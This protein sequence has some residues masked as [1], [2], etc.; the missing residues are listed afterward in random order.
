M[1]T[2]EPKP[3]VGIPRHAKEPV[4]VDERTGL[5]GAQ[6]AD[7]THGIAVTILGDPASGFL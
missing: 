4:Q 5:G 7:P 3:G 2:Q 1:R 6:F